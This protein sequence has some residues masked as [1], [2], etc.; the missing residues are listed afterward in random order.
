MD[1]SPQRIE[2]LDIEQSF[3]IQAPAGSGKTE[4]ITQR[5]LKLLAHSKNPEEVLLMTFT[6]KA[7]MELNERVI[8]SLLLKQDNIKNT[9]HKKTTYDLAQAVLKQSEKQDWNILNNPNRLNIITIDSL[10]NSIIQQN[11]HNDFTI[12]ENWRI[13]EIYQTVA[14]NVLKAIDDADYTNEI[15]SV[16]THLDNST[17]RFI[18]LIVLMLE[19]RDQWLNQLFKTNRKNL[20]DT[21][22]NIVKKHL[23]LLKKETKYLFDNEFYKQVEVDSH[24]QNLNF[25]EIIKEKLLTQKG[26]WRKKIIKDFPHFEENTKLQDLLI[27]LD[28]LPSKNYQDNEWQILKDISQVLKLCLAE[29]QIIFKKERITDYIEIHQ[30]ALNVLGESDNPSDLALYLDYKTQHILIDEFQDTSFSQYNLLEKLISGWQ[31]NENKSLFIVGDPMQSIYGFRQAE[32]GLFLKIAKEGIA[33]I[34]PKYLTLNLNFRS[35]QAIVE[36]N[37]LFF[38]KIFPKEN[39]LN[40]GAISYTKSATTN[41]KKDN[42]AVVFHPFN[43]NE[44]EKQAHKIIEI[45]KKI[46]KNETCAILVRARTHLPEIIEA[47]NKNNINF[48]TNKLHSLEE[49]W[50]VRDLLLLVQLILNPNDKITFLSILRSPWCGLTLEELL[51]VSNNQNEPFWYFLQKKQSSFNNKKLNYFLSA[52]T[53]I[54][55]RKDTQL[56]STLLVIICTRLDIKSYLNEIELKIQKIFIETLMLAEKNTDFSINQLKNILSEKSI[57]SLE[58]KIKILTIYEAKGLEFD[59]VILPNLHKATKPND[60]NIIAFSKRLNNEFIIS[61]IKSNK[62]EKYNKIYNHID[63]I[64]NKKSQFEIMRVLYVAMTRAKSKLHLLSASKTNKNTL[65][66]Y[67][68]PLFIE[69][70]DEL[71]E[72]TQQEEITKTAPPLKFCDF[73][74]KP[75]L[76]NIESKMSILDYQKNTTKQDLGI[77]IH[78]YLEFEIQPNI[79]KIKNDLNNLGFLDDDITKYSQVIKKILDNTKN[80]NCGQWIFKKRDST[81]TEITFYTPNHQAFIIDRLF[82]EDNVLWIIDFKTSHKNDNQSLDE[83]EK[84]QLNLYSK[85]LNNY[86]NLV[87]N[88]NSIKPFNNI[89]KL[90]Y[91]PAIPHSIEVL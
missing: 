13:K 1:D 7:M 61:P 3:I 86:Q 26:D 76:Q 35:T 43:P 28:N 47:L 89:K 4:L 70:F 27:E 33:N 20:E 51:L 19:K 45:I 6:K 84:E 29:L 67:L 38:S 68:K 69:K 87:E 16:L 11:N 25:W 44:E 64:N 53:P 54:L 72:I 63:A 60:K 57:P 18:D 50:L 88:Y 79:I 9:P 90:L 49:H 12:A 32:V 46:P 23:D 14:T 22:N 91:Y 24:K 56:L 81:K 41:T 5:Y 48:E 10:S 21:L 77:L 78:H 59:N 80:D 82:I 74:N 15:T 55:I 58:S 39:N 30:N 31:E 83:F 8:S 52:I 73:N 42:N 34:K 75:T 2:A 17:K 71:D 37:N 85:Q 66:H 36:A 40:L 65:M 62:E